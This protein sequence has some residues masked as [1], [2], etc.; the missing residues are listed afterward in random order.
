M[1]VAAS[2]RTLLAAR[3]GSRWLLPSLTC[4]EGTRAAPVVAR[5]CAGRGL[6]SDV[7]G[8]WLGRVSGNATDWLMVLVAQ[9]ERAH[10]AGPL[11]WIPLDAAVSSESIIEYQTWAL[12]RVLECAALPTVAGPFG[13]LQWPEAARTWIGESF[14]CSVYAWTPYRVSAHEVVF[15]TE[16]SRGRVYF[17][18]LAGDRAAEG[19]M[20]RA[21]AAAA[22]ESFAR[23]LALQVNDRASVWW[24]T[25]HC[26]GRPTRDALQVAAALAPIQQR[27][28]SLAADLPGLKPLDL[29][30]AVEWACEG[31]DSSAIAAIREAA[32]RV[33]QSSMP[34][35]WIPMDLDPT[36]VLSGEDGVR[37]IDVD[38]SFIGPA[39]LA[40]A[41]FARRCGGANGYRRYQDAWSPPLVNVDW[42]SVEIASAVFGAWRGWQ[43]VKTNVERGEVHAALDVVSA[44]IHERLARTIYR[45]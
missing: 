8:Q 15:G 4:G 11:E 5:W 22:P 28:A 27:F 23:T 40:M 3:Y 25:G 18:G 19:T 30:T 17:K 16:T 26:E 29:P 34:R 10:E 32:F 31:L 41:V 6:A 44:R 9:P 43:R 2:S 39:P 14:G 35:T 33:M 36:N 20:T 38:E 12:S 7:A 24:L 13:N 42:T 45:R 37:F 21:F 1:I